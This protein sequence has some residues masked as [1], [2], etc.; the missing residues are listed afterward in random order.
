MAGSLTLQVSY[1]LKPMLKSQRNLSS[2]QL[3]IQTLYHCFAKHILTGVV[4]DRKIL[5]ETLFMNNTML[6]RRRCMHFSETLLTL[7]RVN[8]GCF[9]GYIFSDGSLQLTYVPYNGIILNFHCKRY[10]YCRRWSYIMT[11]EINNYVIC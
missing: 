1:L 8:S 7:S 6:I 5:R 3:D 11:N 10:I 2:M 9:Q 4:P